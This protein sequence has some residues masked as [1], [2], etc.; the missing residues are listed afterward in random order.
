M[1]ADGILLLSEEYLTREAMGMSCRCC[2]SRVEAFRFATE[3]IDDQKLKTP[4]KRGFAMCRQE[5][6]DNKQTSGKAEGQGVHFVLLGD[7]GPA[8]R[9]ATVCAARLQGC[10]SGSR[11]H[12]KLGALGAPARAQ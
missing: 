4:E 2:H 10:E 8:K 3:Q 1:I 5:Q 11:L 7:P 9:G 12:W 6:G